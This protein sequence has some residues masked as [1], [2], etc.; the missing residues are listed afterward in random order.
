MPVIQEAVDLSSGRNFIPNKARY[1]LPSGK[2]NNS[3]FLLSN[4]YEYDIELI[5]RIPS[6]KVDYKTIIIPFKVVDKIDTKPFQYSLNQ[7]DYNNKV[8]YMES[9]KLVPALEVVRP[10]YP[11][12]IMN[13]LYVPISDVIKRMNVYLRSMSVDDIKATA[14]DIFNQIM[15]HFKWSQNRILMIDATRYTIYQTPT[16]TTLKNDIINAMLGAYMLNPADSIRRMNWTIIFRGENAD[17]KLDMNTFDAKDVG[18]LKNMLLTIG[19]PSPGSATTNE[20]A[21]ESVDDFDGED[22]TKSIDN[23]ISALNDAKNNVP[24][25]DEIVSGDADTSD[26][27]LV[28]LQERNRSVTN[29]LK[30]TIARLQSKA[31]NQQSADNDN[32]NQEDKRLY[33]AKTL[34]INA[35]LI[36]RINPD[37]TTLSNYETI[38]ADLETSGNNPVENKIID[39]AAKE[40][41]NDV[42][43][44]DMA[45][46]DN[47]TT[48]ARELEIRKRVGQLKLNN[49]SFDTLATVTDAP[50]P[51]IRKPRLMTTTCAA[52]THGTSFTRIAKEYEDKLLD[53]DIVATF[54]N[55]SS[56]PDGFYVT[57]VEVTDISTVTSLMNNWKVTL[58][59][60]SS[61]KQSVINVRIPKV[62]NG[63]FYNNGVWYN[64]GK[65]DFPIPI[66]KI[67]KKK[68][69]I[70]TNYNKITVERYD[71]RSLVDIGI[72]TKVINAANDANG[73]NKYIKPG[74]SVNTN[75]RFVSTIEYDEYAKQWISFINKESHC[76]IFF[77][78]NQCAK[79]YSFVT[80]QPNE[81]CCG[82]LNQVPIVVNTD[83]GL[84][85]SGLSLTDTM[86]R[87]LPP[88]MID[89]YRKTK[90][91][92]L[93]MYAQIIIGQTMPL[94]VAIAAWEGL[95]TLIKKSGAESKFVD[96]RFSD[97][98]FITI[99]FK[100]KI[101]AIRNTT[102]NQLIFNGFYRLPTKAYTFMEFNTPIMHTNSIYVDIF[103]QMFFKQYSQLTTF[104]TYYQFFVDAI[105]KDVCL[106]Y[107]IPN[108]IAGMLLYA[109]NLLA[110]NSFTGETNAALY[111]VRSSEIIPAILHYRLAYNISR[112]NNSVG[113]KARG[114]TFTFNPNEV[115][116]ELRQV[117]NVNPISALNP[118]VE[119]HAREE[120]TKKGF[121]GVND[122]RA[123]NVAKR[124]FDDSM[125]GK[126]AMSTPNSGNVG[127]SR[128]LTADPKLT[129]TRGYTDTKGVDG[130]YNDLQLASFSELL[131]PGT[132][133]RDDAI[134][135]AIATSQTSHIVP[136]AEAQPCLISNGVDELLP[137]CLT[138]EFSVIADDD[139]V[140]LDT[141]EDY[142][143]IQ[144]KSGNKRAIN[145]GHRQSFN[146]GSGFFVDNKLKSNFEK[147]DKFQKDDILAYH[148]KHFS[149]GNDGVVRAN[150]GPL[151]KVAFMA[152]YST[153]EDAGIMTTKMSKRLATSVIM[154][155]RHKLNATDDIEKIVKVGDYVEIG[156]PL[157]VFGLGDTGDKAVDNFMRAFQK[158][159]SNVMDSAKRMIRA[160]DA[161]KVVD[162]RI[163]TCKS[164]DRL[165][166]SLYEIID[167]HFKENVK[168]RK[169]LDKYEKG[170]DVYKMGMLYDR[171]TQPLKGSTIMG[172]T[173]DVLVDIYIEHED[174]ASVGDKCVAYAASKQVLSE[175]IPEG[176]EPYAESNPD[177]E[178][179]MFVS[180]AS[181]LKRMIPSIMIIASGNKVL[182]E[183]K[184]KIRHLWENSQN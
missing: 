25:E 167:N 5:K 161:G 113:S 106:H 98:G 72:F 22:E 47:V 54:M 139:G 136:T 29:D 183:L 77:D 137:A 63:R 1:K 45:Q 177:E 81:F 105:T 46:A 27:E 152:L 140:V 50:L 82:M 57:N 172:I 141:N 174:E 9:Q 36:S 60:K 42:Q 15:S 6:P 73:K 122:D 130:D 4:S 171:P 138:D 100:D 89:A 40:L 184:S 53:R 10:P 95:S 96:A 39:T 93:S 3:I 176:L 80:V 131:T 175:V 158:E 7:N 18:A 59:N 86:L 88:D 165:S 74:S 91:G 30:D 24:N 119:L 23:E 64:I 83:T 143:I 20:E 13:N 156:D 65:Q 112:Y 104:I 58:K 56:L 85:R 169:M 78:R 99:P 159:G 148:E 2:T 151:A 32:A 168:K 162:V 33:N 11:K 153:Y 111:R 180:S 61:D 108:D 34:A 150:I 12:T 133:S 49:V 178:I 118:M 110:D 173:C 52:A 48:S 124:S 157:V 154:R 38:A 116:D 37:K 164:M 66:L 126:V 134:R 102:Q 14:F 129:S 68:V 103:N 76:E 62:V 69:I 170:N 90:P 132:V 109:S 51:V 146:S 145:I 55:L 123:Y 160:K 94:G 101:L 44:A 181:I 142:M 114:A 163:Y 84:T 16:K 75:S 182:V 71:T 28:K 166:P 117:Q 107:N 19:K 8:K 155:S 147:G 179:S 70:T 125:I 35:Q 115:I 135:T 21:G 121:S 87:T 41:A 17:Y 127:I 97:T 120:I 31:D 92:K 144:Y 128:Q 79:A 26:P 149:K 43:P 67:S